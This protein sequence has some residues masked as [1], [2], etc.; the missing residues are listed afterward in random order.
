MQS[1]SFLAVM[2]AVAPLELAETWD[3]VGLLIA[4]EP[5]ELRRVLLTIDLTEEVVEEGLEHQVDAIV[6]YHPPIFA[7]LKRIVSADPLGRMVT[8]LISNNVLV[9]SPHTALD[10][11]PGGVNDWLA[12]A[13][14]NSSKRAIIPNESP[15]IGTLFPDQAVGQGR[16]LSLQETMHLDEIIPLLKQHLRLAHLRVSCASVHRHGAISSVAL[17][18]GSGGP[19]VTSCE[20]DLYLTGEMRHHDVLASKAKGTSVILTDH[21][22]T[23]RGYLP[24]LEEQIRRRCSDL[25]VRVSARDHDPLSIV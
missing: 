14:P 4:A 23:E 20:A 5:R 15:T 13:F 10:A 2:H 21:T 7:G 8:R 16:V 6:A 1:A 24:L 17:C 3:N 19:V 22:N 9:Y 18:A 25:D 12:A 11:V